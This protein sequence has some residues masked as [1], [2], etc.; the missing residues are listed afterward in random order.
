MKGFKIRSPSKD[1]YIKNRSKL[2][3]LI[4]GSKQFDDNGIILL[5]GPIEVSIYD[6]DTEYLVSPEN[7]FLFLFGVAE[8]NTYGIIEHSN[9]TATL[10][11]KIPDPVK[12]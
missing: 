9:G 1:F 10:F 5:K 3:N 6:D 2:I 7:L 12:T 11:P 4:H 8:P